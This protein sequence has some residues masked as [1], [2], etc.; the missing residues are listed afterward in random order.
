VK[1]V[2]GR[3]PDDHLQD[4]VAQCHRNAEIATSKFEHVRAS[5]RWLMGGIPAWLLALYALVAVK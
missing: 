5:L 1:E 4:L 3:T 2:L